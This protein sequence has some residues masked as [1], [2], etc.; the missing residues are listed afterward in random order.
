LLVVTLIFASGIAIGSLVYRFVEK[1]MLLRINGWLR[2]WQ[3]QA[4]ASD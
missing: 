2:G 4:R 3:A 1:P